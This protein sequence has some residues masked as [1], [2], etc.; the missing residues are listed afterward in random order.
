MNIKNVTKF[1]FSTSTGNAQ[2][3]LKWNTFTV[4]T[5]D[6]SKPI[7]S[8]S[9]W[10]IL[11]TRIN[12]R[13]IFDWKERDIVEAVY[14]NLIKKMRENSKIARTNFWVVDE[15]TG[16]VYVLDSTGHFGRINRDTLNWTN[17]IH[18]FWG[19]KVN[20]WVISNKKLM[21]TTTHPWYAYHRLTADE[22]K[23][24]LKNPLLMQWFV[25]AMNR[26]MW[27]VESVRAWFDR[28]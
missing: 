12:K 1:D 9:L 23:E 5:P 16:H 7:V 26:R 28:N 10:K 6:S 11:N 20:E 3:E 25:K 4:T 21:G 18:R 13:R 27:V 22:E 17:I 14:S 2:I 19:A 15:L 24:L 8:K